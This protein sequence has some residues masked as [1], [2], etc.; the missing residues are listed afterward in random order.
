MV[1]N[2]DLSLDVKRRECNNALAMKS[3]LFM[4]VSLYDRAGFLHRMIR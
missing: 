1:L 4:I 3:S 2:L